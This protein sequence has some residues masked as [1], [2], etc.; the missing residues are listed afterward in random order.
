MTTSCL[1]TEV[2][3]TPETSCISNI[4]QTMELSNVKLVQQ[5]NHCPKP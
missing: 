1:N 5:I 2:Y 4:P 3:L